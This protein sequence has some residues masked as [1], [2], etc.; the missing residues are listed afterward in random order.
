M[1]ATGHNFSDLQNTE[2]L[3]DFYCAWG[4]FRRFCFEGQPAP[5]LRVM[6]DCG[7]MRTPPVNPDVDT[8]EFFLPGFSGFDRD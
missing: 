6:A 1:R 5:S 7:A 2:I 4:C 3:T 8:A